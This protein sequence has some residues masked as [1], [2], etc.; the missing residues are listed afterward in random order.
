MGFLSTVD[1]AVNIE[2][3]GKKRV[4]NLRGHSLSR[5]LLVDLP[6]QIEADKFSLQEYINKI[7]ESNQNVS[8]WTL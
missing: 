4:V 3:K 6:E 8:K 1:N 5:T 2:V 7:N